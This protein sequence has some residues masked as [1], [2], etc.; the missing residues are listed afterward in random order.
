VDYFVF[1]DLSEALTAIQNI[2]SA[3]TKI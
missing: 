2:D 3:S 1:N